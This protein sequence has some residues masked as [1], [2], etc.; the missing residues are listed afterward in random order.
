[1]PSLPS[2][3][4]VRGSLQGRRP[5]SAI[6]RRIPHRPCTKS[7][8]LLCCPSTY[9]F[10]VSYHSQFISSLPRQWGWLPRNGGWLYQSAERS[11]FCW[12]W[13]F[14]AKHR[15]IRSQTRRSRMAI[16]EDIHSRLEELAGQCSSPVVVTLG[17]A[18]QRHF[19]LILAVWE[20]TW[21]D[22]MAWRV[23]EWCR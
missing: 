11:A 8:L 18:R 4:S 6:A 2:A 9:A 23:P 1:M 7:Q 12:S 21:W 3:A 16:M 22:R 10:A 20:E 5:T 19:F 13:V 15:W 14:W 17:F